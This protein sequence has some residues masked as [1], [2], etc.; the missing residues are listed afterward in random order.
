[1]VPTLIPQ[2]GIE[3]PVCNQK[4]QRCAS[5]YMAGAWETWDSPLDSSNCA[6]ALCPPSKVTSS[7]TCSPT[8]IGNQ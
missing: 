6:R 1:M 3:I 7:Q 5:R 4:M 2:A 8:L